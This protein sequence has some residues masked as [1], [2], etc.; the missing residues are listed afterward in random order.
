MI[1]A[2]AASLAVLACRPPGARGIALSAAAG[3]PLPATPAAARALE[4]A[5]A[6]ARAPRRRPPPWGFRGAR[7]ARPLLT[8]ILTR[9]RVA[10]GYRRSRAG[11]VIEA[12]HI[13]A[14]I[15]VFLNIFSQLYQRTTTPR[16]DCSINN[17]GNGHLPST[18]SPAPYTHEPYLPTCPTPL[19]ILLAAESSDVSTAVQ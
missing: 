4:R 17:H 3:A 1:A 15:P 12:V 2:S 8:A 11:V 7:A 19:H 10:S 13:I 5:L 14:G 6:P 16:D 9:C 18:L